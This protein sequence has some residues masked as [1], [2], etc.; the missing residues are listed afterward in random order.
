MKSHRRQESQIKARAEGQLA[1]QSRRLQSNLSSRPNRVTGDQIQHLMAPLTTALLAFRMDTAGTTHYHDLAAGL[2]VAFYTASRVQRHQHT[3]PYL[4]AGLDALTAVFTR[5]QGTDNYQAVPAETDAV[6]TA[7]EVYRSLL[8]VT[9]WSFLRRAI[10]DAM[11][12]SS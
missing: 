7:V 2:T 5:A 3:L 8:H 11:P 6:E 10:S 12:A 1:A 9:S 4:Q